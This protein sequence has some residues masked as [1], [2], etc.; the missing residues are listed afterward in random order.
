ME[1]VPPA[2]KQ[3]RNVEFSEG[4]HQSYEDDLTKI[5][6]KIGDTQ[7]LVKNS[8]GVKLVI[9]KVDMLELQYSLSLSEKKKMT[10]SSG[11]VPKYGLKDTQKDMVIDA[12]D[13]AGKPS[14]E[15]L[16]KNTSVNAIS[17]IRAAS[18]EHLVTAV[19]KY[20]QH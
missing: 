11:D 12:C 14:K 15:Q 19:W 1:G 13:L 10:T 6:T 3:V 20:S 4:A 16:D 5:M 17:S 8:T 7:H 18:F 2:P 9:A